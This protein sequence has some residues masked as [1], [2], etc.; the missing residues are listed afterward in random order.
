MKTEI[1][2]LAIAGAVIANHVADGTEY[3]H[4]QALH[5]QHVADLIDDCI[6]DSECEAAAAGIDWRDE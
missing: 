3:E 4:S 1:F 6:T 5:A 2:T